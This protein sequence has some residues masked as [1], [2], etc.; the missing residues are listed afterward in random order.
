MV[1]IQLDYSKKIRD[2]YDTASCRVKRYLRQY[3]ATEADLQDRMLYGIYCE[4][5]T[6]VKK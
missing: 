1:E 3:G 6:S 4:A 2:Y 5:L